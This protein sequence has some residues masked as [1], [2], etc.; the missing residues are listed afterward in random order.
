MN[1]SDRSLAEAWY[2]SAMRRHYRSMRDH[3][4]RSLLY[5]LGLSIL[6]G[7]VWG[8]FR[9]AFE[10]LGNTGSGFDMFLEA[11]V[12]LAAVFFG[13]AGSALYSLIKLAASERI[14]RTRQKSNAGQVDT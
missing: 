9:G 2:E 10:A 1:E 6:M 7:I 11:I 8:L 12:T 14:R 5:W 4:R 3:Y 13:L